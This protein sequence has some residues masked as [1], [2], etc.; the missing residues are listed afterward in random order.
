[1]STVVSVGREVS[2]ENLTLQQRDAARLDLNL[3][4]DHKETFVLLRRGCRVFQTQAVH[5][6]RKKKRALSVLCPRPLI[7]PAASVFMPT[8]A[9]HDCLLTWMDVY[10]RVCCKRFSHSSPCTPELL[11]AEPVIILA[12]IY[13]P[14]ISSKL[15]P[16]WLSFKGVGEESDEETGFFLLLIRHCRNWVIYSV[17]VTARVLRRWVTAF[18]LQPLTVDIQIRGAER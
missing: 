12:G 2:T 14:H 6:N 11:S 13:T 10:G 1:M 8:V 15:F 17:A 7:T 4:S 18:R 9:E 3:V 5:T 16:L